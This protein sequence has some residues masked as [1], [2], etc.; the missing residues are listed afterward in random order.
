MKPAPK[1]IISS[2]F[3]PPN[4]VRSAEHQPHC[5]PLPHPA[6]ESLQEFVGVIDSRRLQPGARHYNGSICKWRDSIFLAYRYEQFDAVSK[7]GICELDAGFRVIRDA[8]V[9]IPAQETVH[10]EDPRLTVI[11]DRMILQFSH[12]RLGVP[13]LCRQRM[14]VIGEDFSFVEEI[15]LPFGG[16]GI[17]KNWS[18]FE[19]PNGNTGLVYGQSPRLVIEV[20]TRAGA[21]SKASIVKPPGSSLSGRTP[22]IRINNDHFLEFVGGHI[23]TQPRNARY[24]FAAQLFQ[25]SHPH[26]VVAGTAPLVW[27][28]EASPTLFSPRPYAGHPLCIF[29]SGVMREGNDGVI[30]SCGVNDSYIALLRFN[31]GTLLEQMQP[32]AEEEA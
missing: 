26:A 21:W 17:E 2:G 22:P 12:V 9:P 5:I 13:P 10:Y 27:G 6:I 23:A 25:A 19:L 4:P 11:G 20:E 29:P 16:N 18:P 8:E 31:I 32:V 28:T 1:T 24:W 30:V 15:A 7:V 3:L 14:A